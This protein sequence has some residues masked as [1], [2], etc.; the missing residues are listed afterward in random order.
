MHVGGSVLKAS[1]HSFP[2][3]L[4]GTG[5]QGRRWP[6]VLRH[7]G[8]VIKQKTAG[9]IESRRIKLVSRYFPSVLAF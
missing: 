1:C 7:H 3:W 8:T 9:S 6:L 4:V 5:H 2:L